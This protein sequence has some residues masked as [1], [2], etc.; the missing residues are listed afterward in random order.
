VGYDAGKKIKGR[1][2]HALVDTEGFPLRVIVHSAGIQDR[3][4]AALVLNRIRQRFNWLELVWADNGYNAYQVNNAIAANPGLRIEIV[5]RS[6][7]M[8]GFVVLPR[9]WVVERTFSWLM[10]HRRLVRDYE[11]LPETHEAMVKWAMIAIILNRLAPRPGP[12]P[13]ASKPNAK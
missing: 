5:K 12:K 13:W 11:R 10:R 4:G 1:K 3:D 8:K 6:D 2:L 9:R 7:D